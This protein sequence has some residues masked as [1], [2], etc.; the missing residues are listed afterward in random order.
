MTDKL[1]VSPLAAALAAAA[2][3]AALL[4]GGG[5]TLDVRTI[6]GQLP[7]P[8]PS[9]QTL[10]PPDQGVTLSDIGAI[11]EDSLRHETL[12]EQLPVAL[13]RD[14]RSA[15][16]WLR[17][18]WSSL[19]EGERIIAL[20]IWTSLD[21]SGAHRLAVELDRD[22]EGLV[23]TVLQAWAAVEP[24][25]AAVAAARGPAPSA[26]TLEEMARLWSHRDPEAALRFASS[27]PVASLRSGAVTTAVTVWAEA[28]APAAARAVAALPA[29][30]TRLPLVGQVAAAWAR[31]DPVAAAAWASDITAPDERLT[32]LRIIDLEAGGG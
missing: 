31:R 32:A 4:I 28:D 18:A 22:H 30:P 5:L 3:L 10:T 9:P 25:Q 13:A 16:D 14:A 15:E 12:R 1:R 2:L 26:A 27:Y 29:E 23:D 19:D 6:G 20:R 24:E 7:P 11:P 8:A 17:S 21:G